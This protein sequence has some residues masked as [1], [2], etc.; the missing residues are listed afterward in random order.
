MAANAESYGLPLYKAMAPSHEQRF[1]DHHIFRSDLLGLF[2]N[3]QQYENG[4][5]NGSYGE[6]VSVSLKTLITHTFKM[7]RQTS[8][9]VNRPDQFAADLVLGF[10]SE[11]TSP[12]PLVGQVAGCSHRLAWVGQ[13]E[14]DTVLSPATTC[15]EAGEGASLA[16]VKEEG[17]VDSET[18]VGSV[19]AV[20]DEFL[21]HRLVITK[22][23]PP[24][25]VYSVRGVRC[26]HCGKPFRSP[27]CVEQLIE[28][29]K[30]MHPLR[31][32]P[33][34]IRLLRKETSFKNV[35]GNGMPYCKCRACRL[36]GAASLDKTLPLL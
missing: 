36:F 18:V 30:R 10:L 19:L 24:H 21:K 35:L 28:H 7:C 23:V 15:F 5:W 31:A 11:A 22:D 17:G 8:S 33:R 25:V 14:N 4:V 34:H 29:T 2:K 13:G 27:T 20:K 32:T 3:F 12:V 16:L 6:N 9:Y 1:F 26:C